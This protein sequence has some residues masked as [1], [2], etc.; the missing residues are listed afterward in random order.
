MNICYRLII[1]GLA[2]FTG[3]Y[4]SACA[5]VPEQSKLLHHNFI[6]TEVNGTAFIGEKIPNIQF[7][8]GLKV[9]GSVC[10]NYIGQGELIGDKLFVRELAS[11][12]MLCPDQDLN[13]L[14]FAFGNM[15]MA[16]ATISYNWNTLTLVGD[17]Y[18]LKFKLQDLVD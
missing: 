10:N 8:E 17:G 18:R 13:E 15:L 5:G 6:L 3:V 9:S 12:K 2:V 1:F 4:S 14:E 11:T 16:G 7:G